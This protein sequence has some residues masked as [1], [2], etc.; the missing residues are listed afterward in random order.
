MTENVAFE[1]FTFGIFNGL[2][3]TQNVNVGRFANNFEWDFFVI[4]KSQK[5]SKNVLTH[6]HALKVF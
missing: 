4:W 6:G 5:V 3:A 2:L 1:F